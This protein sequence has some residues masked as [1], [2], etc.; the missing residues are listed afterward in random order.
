MHGFKDI[1]DLPWLTWSQLIICGHGFD[2][3]NSNG[4]ITYD[5]YFN[6]T[7]WQI[8]IQRKTLTPQGTF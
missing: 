5:I 4:F 6:D 3:Y 7:F 1:S 2:F 8:P